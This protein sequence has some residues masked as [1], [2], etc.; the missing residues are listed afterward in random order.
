MIPITPTIKSMVLS[1]KMEKIKL[2][3]DVHIT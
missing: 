2:T 1:E 3:G